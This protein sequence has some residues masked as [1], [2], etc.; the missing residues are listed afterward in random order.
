MF[1]LNRSEKQLQV[2]W[3]PA[4][5]AAGNSLA[6]HVTLKATFH[7]RHDACAELAVE[8]VDGPMGDTPYAGD[9]GLG[10]YYPNDFTPR[11]PRGE[12]L[13]A[14]SVYPP[15]GKAPKAFRA[16][17]H[18]GPVSKEVAVFG[19]RQWES[20]FLS[21]RPGQPA[22]AIPTP[23]S[24]RFAFGGPGFPLN[25][26]GCG[27]EGLEMPRLEHL[28][29]SLDAPSNL[30]PPAGLGAIP[31]DWAPRISRLGSFGADYAKT[32]WPWWPHDFDRR[33]FQTAPEDQQRDGYWD[34]SEELVFLNLH[35]TVAEFR[36]SLPGVLPRCFART[37]S[38]AKRGLAPG[39][40]EY[41]TSEI[42][43]ELDTIWVDPSVEKLVLNWR[44][45]TAI[46]SIV[47]PEI[48]A[49]WCR[50]ELPGDDLGIVET[51]AADMQE[52]D[53]LDDPPPLSPSAEPASEA[54]TPDPKSAAELSAIQQ[55]FSN[56]V[57]AMAGLALAK[58]SSGT[59]EAIREAITGIE[60][61]LRQLSANAEPAKAA[62][63]AQ[64]LEQ[65][66][67]NASAAAE[68]LGALP[69][70]SPAPQS[71]SPSA[72]EEAAQA[73]L[74]DLEQKF[75]ELEASFPSSVRWED[76]V[77]EGVFSV[78]ELRAKG[79]RHMDFRGAPLIGLDLSRIDFSGAVFTGMDLSGVS[80]SHSSL[81]A[82]GL[83][84]CILD[85]C[86]FSATDLSLATLA[87]VQTQGTLWDGAL[88]GDA[89]FEEVDFRETNLSGLQA[90]R[91]SFRECQMQG[92]D[93]SR[94]LLATAQFP[95]SDLS[96]ANLSESILSG[97]DLRGCKASKANFSC[98]H[99]EALRA[100]EA[101]VFAG[102]TFRDAHISGAILEGS[103]L[104]NCDFSGSDLTGAR[105]VGA[106]ASAAIFEKCDLRKAAFDDAELREALF[107]HANLME[108]TFDRANCTLV[109]FDGANLFD[110]SF[111]E[112]ELLH[113][114]WRGAYTPRTRFALT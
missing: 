44:G 37:I 100:D 50:L 63:K 52:M 4:P 109:V 24:Y 93:L 53:A 74:R 88:C 6:L 71:E 62:A 46:R 68:G 72:A 54:T 41:V 81:Q 14:G 43:L 31:M 35:P 87:R 92:V 112:S 39:D 113:A 12:V 66:R 97:A 76:F 36:T 91:A 49:L 16:G 90:P 96:G 42:P 70:D 64:E 98:C 65:V 55:V 25:P 108:S 19:P 38:N 34:G 47:F 27:K 79:G 103:D 85:R 84:D 67:A 48:H 56:S 83:S 3:H 95:G 89:T 26:I 32:R 57:A 9:A 33:F 2:C 29:R 15:N 110:A 77:K 17:I 18:A 111:W 51:V 106:L 1:L 86:Q 104:S 114:S 30:L 10:L 78:Q 45:E 102:A 99:L 5:S 80:F 61:P 7:I 40:R 58:P 22:Q 105:F 94:T 73:K 75:A 59:P 101:T 82:A 21:I 20:S 23:L 60:E 8:G 107:A 69:G 13:V 28:V 11:K